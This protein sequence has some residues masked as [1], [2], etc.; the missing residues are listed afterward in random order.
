MISIPNKAVWPYIQQWHLD[1]QRELLRNTVASISYVGSKGTHLTRV[2]DL[3]QIPAVPLSQN[4]FGPG[5]A[6][7]QDICNSLTDTA[8]DVY[9]NTITDQNVVNHINVACG[10]NPDPFRTNFPGIGG[11][12]GLEQKAS[13]IY[14]GLQ[15]SVRR[16]VGALQLSGSYTYSH[17]IDDSSSARDGRYIDSYNVPIARASSNFDQ[18]HLFNLGYV[19]DLP[20]FKQPG[21]S[22]TLLGGWQWSGITTIQTGSPFSVQNSQFSDNAG[23]SNTF[24]A[25]NSASS[26]PDLVGNPNSGIQKFPFPAGGLGRYCSTPRRLWLRAASPLE[27]PPETS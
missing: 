21:L 1:V 11:I 17:S 23:V 7:T 14:H 18:R 25:N 27:T 20:F 9:G 6:L 24:A 8:V 26:Y 22:R 13:S 12:T 2:R 3:N 15:I 16:S 4:P 5:Q 10:G 19:Y